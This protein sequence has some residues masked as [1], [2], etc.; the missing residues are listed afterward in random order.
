MLLSAICCWFLK[1]FC[2]L[3]SLPLHAYCQ[4]WQSLWVTRA[5]QGPLWAPWAWL[6][7]NWGGPGLLFVQSIHTLCLDILSALKI[8]KNWNKT[9]P[10]SA[11]SKL[12]CTRRALTCKGVFILVASTTTT[13]SSDESN[14]KGSNSTSTDSDD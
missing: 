8:K 11:L 13:V 2:Q 7:N 5:L 3:K 1:T 9:C 6:T 4:F 14:Y 10:R 12:A